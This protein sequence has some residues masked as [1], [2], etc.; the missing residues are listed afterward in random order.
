MIFHLGAPRI[1]EKLT[2][3]AAIKQFALQALTFVDSMFG[4]S[5]W[6]KIY[7]SFSQ[8]SILSF[9]IGVLSVIIFYRIAQEDNKEYNSKLIISL[10]VLLFSSFLMFAVTGRYPQLAFNLGNRV[11]IYGSLL[12]SY[13]IV[14]IPV[15][16]KI[17]TLVFTLVIFTILGIS[18]HW[19]NWNLHQQMVIA[20]IKDNQDLNRYR[21]DKI[22]YVSGSQYSKYGPISHIE[23]LS[24]DWVV[25]RIFKLVVNKD[26][27]AKSLNKRHKYING[28]LIDTK[29]NIKDKVTS[30]ISIYDSEKDILF[31]LRVGEVNDYINSLP[32]DNRHWVQMLDARLMKG[33]A[34]K[35]MP[36]LK[37]AL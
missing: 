10:L 36:R 27:S 9:V 25:D 16:K 37:Y 1:I 18:D 34:V 23:F 19:K 11:T 31:K 14:L 22:I 35:L 5:M 12:L 30:Y 32:P 21:E 2:V 13:L 20:N 17:K 29:Y 33:I 24:E 28:Y 15:S 7:F 3:L 6:L 26:I 4:P 8:L